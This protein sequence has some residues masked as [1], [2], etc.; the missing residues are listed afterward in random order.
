MGLFGRRNAG[1]PAEGVFTD[2][3]RERIDALWRLTA[4]PREEFEA[5]YGD[6]LAGFWRSI[7]KAPGVAWIVLRD[8]ALTS[9][10]AAL[11]VRQARIVPRSAPVE[12][13]LEGRSR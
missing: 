13:E 6:M 4:L 2:G 5:T 10:L 8:E 11:K 7:A 9:A 12:A 3:E 1:W